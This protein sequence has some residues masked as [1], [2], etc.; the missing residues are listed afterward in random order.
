MAT[1][2]GHALVPKLLR[3]VHP[4]EGR[5]AKLVLLRAVKVE[6]GELEVLPP[7]V[8]HPEDAKYTHEVERMLAGR[9]ASSA[10]AGH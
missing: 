10:P 3:M 1:L 7:L 9:A 2:D 5:S 6:Y 8:L 4:R